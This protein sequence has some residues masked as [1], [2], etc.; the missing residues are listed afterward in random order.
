MLTGPSMAMWLIKHIQFSLSHIYSEIIG[1]SSREDRDE[2]ANLVLYSE[3]REFGHG[4]SHAGPS[5]S[6]KAQLK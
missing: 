2:E 1:E 5:V 6:I 3:N 4:D